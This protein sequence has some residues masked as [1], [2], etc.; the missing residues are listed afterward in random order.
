MLYTVIDIFYEFFLIY[1][2][3]RYWNMIMDL[4]YQW[5]NKHFFNL[6]EVIELIL[7]LSVIH[8]SFYNIMIGSITRNQ[9]VLVKKIAESWIRVPLMIFALRSTE[10]YSPPSQMSQMELFVKVLNGFKPFF[11]LFFQKAPS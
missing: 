8:C 5:C 11:N 1:F 4:V 9:L 10:R 3:F 2:I 6:R 7:N